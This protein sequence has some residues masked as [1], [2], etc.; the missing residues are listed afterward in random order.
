MAVNL[1]GMNAE[2]HNAATANKAEDN[3]KCIA[4]LKKYNKGIFAS[5][6]GAYASPV[7]DLVKKGS[8]VSSKSA[9]NVIPA[10]VTNMPEIALTNTFAIA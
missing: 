5:N 7:I 9:Y 6:N 4:E 3:D 10:N 8:F 2:I 1:F